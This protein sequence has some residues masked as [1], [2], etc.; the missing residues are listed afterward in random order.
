M[1]PLALFL[2]VVATVLAPADEASAQLLPAGPV[3]W[4][5]SVDGLRIGVS[6]LA[7]VEP[8]TSASFE[9]SLQNTGT[10]D[11]VVNLGQMLGNGRVMFPSA[12]RPVLTDSSGSRRELE[13]ADRRY[14]AIAGR[15]DDFIVALRAGS[16]YVLRLSLDQY[17]TPVTKEFVVKPGPGRSRMW[18][19]FQGTGA[20]TRNSDMQGVGLLKF[21]KGTVQSGIV[22]FEVPQR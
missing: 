14:P 10:E 4:G 1:K 19:G 11:F 18:V 5:A 20:T 13:Y 8:E 16:T 22:E 3:A 21:W 6:A 9:V 17:W 12:V 15:L 7:G 2:I